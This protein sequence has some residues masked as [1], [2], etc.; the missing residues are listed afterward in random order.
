MKI[1][2]HVHLTSPEMQQ[3][4]EDV[5]KTEPYFS[6]LSHSKS[7][8]FAD[9]ED[10]VREMDAAGFDK[11]VVFG[12]AFQQ[13]ENCQRANDYVAEALQRFPDRLIACAVV[14]PT[15]DGASEEIRRCADMGFSGIGELYCQ[16]QRFSPIELKTN[17]DI[18]SCC[19]QLGWPIYFHGNEQ[20]GHRYPGKTDDGPEKLFQLVELFPENRFVF[21]HWGGGLCFYELMPEMKTKFQ[22]VYYDTAATPYLY[23]PEIYDTAK[24]IQ[25]LDKVV[26]GS[27]F[28][29]LGL[30]RT[31]EHMQRSHLTIEE[32]EKVLGENVYRLFGPHISC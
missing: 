14:S 9:A 27:D 23:E 17:S 31:Q 4:W 10:L 21:A 29:L 7:N 8:H 16:G 18:M 13:L 6:L 32:Q 24:A 25:I 28:P 22:N 12:F 19:Q 3:R 30:V 20:V 1:D 26:F 11:A 2:A 5:A 15:V